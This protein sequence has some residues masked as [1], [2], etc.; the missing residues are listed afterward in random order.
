[1]LK[2]EIKLIQASVSGWLSSEIWVN[3]KLLSHMVTV[4]FA[5]NAYSCM[6]S[7]VFATVI[8]KFRVCAQET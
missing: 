4:Q 1:M 7:L 6:L 5:D 2:I 8:Y 3:C